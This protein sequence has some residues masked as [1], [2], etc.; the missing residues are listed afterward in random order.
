VTCRVPVL[1][2]DSFGGVDGVP[3]PFLDLRSLLSN[4]DIFGGLVKPRFYP[5]CFGDDLL[6]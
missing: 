2:P 6:G 5:C 1:F 4:A 3:Q